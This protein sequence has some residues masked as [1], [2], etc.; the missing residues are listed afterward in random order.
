VSGL[1]VQGAGGGAPGTTPRALPKLDA[2]HFLNWDFAYMN[3]GLLAPVQV[4]PTAPYRA[5]PATTAA[6][7]L[8]AADL[9]VSFA[10][11]GGGPFTVVGP[12]G[13]AADFYTLSSATGGMGTAN[14]P[15]S[16]ANNT[17]LTIEAYINLKIQTVTG[18]SPIFSK[19]FAHT[20]GAPFWSFELNLTNS[21]DGTIEY[22]I[23]DTA[24]PAAEIGT[25]TGGRYRIAPGYHHLALVVDTQPVTKKGR[26][27]IDGGEVGN[28]AITTGIDFSDGP[29]MFGGN[30]VNSDSS[31]NCQYTRCCISTVARSPAYL[32]AAAQA[33]L[34]V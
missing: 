10:T 4:A 7:N 5:T 25:T 23:T 14:A 33:F 31:N 28:F 3:N 8:H 19:A 24:A 18:N 34:C 15:P 2:F 21:L 30:I 27:Y 9:S 32:L 22:G 11:N 26:L 29:Y 12:F 6:P 17:P 16:P 1:F 20:W 13:R